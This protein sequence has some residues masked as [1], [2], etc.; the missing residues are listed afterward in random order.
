MFGKIL[1]ANR[2]EIACRIIQ[3]C[4]EL[5]IRT[6]AVYSQADADSLHVKLADEAV[7]IGPPP[8]RQSYLHIPAILGAA[9]ITRADAIHPGYGFLSENAEFAEKCRENDL[10]F[11]GPPPAAIAMMGH[12]AQARAVMIEAGVPV[13]PGSTGTLTNLDDALETARRIGF[14][15]MIKAAA[16]GG[17]RGMRIVRSE[18][19]LPVHFESAQAE[20]GAAFNNP[21]V[22]IEKYIEKPRHIEFQVLADSH[23]NVIHLGERECSI[24][25]R[26]QKLIEESPSPVM[27]PQLRERMGA[28]AVDACRKVGYVNAG[29]I[30]FLVD[31]NL[32]FYFMEMNTRIQVEH[33][34]TELVTGIDL[35]RWQ[36]RIAA[37]E[38]L[39]FTQADVRFTGHA[40]ECRLNAEDPVKFTPSPGPIVA[41]RFP[42]GP[43]VRVDSQLYAGYVVP[44]HYDSMIGKLVVHDETRT[45]AIARM[46]RALAATVIDG[47]KTTVPL[48]QKVLAEPD[49]INGN[50]S[51]R[52]MDRYAAEPKQ[53]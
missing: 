42:G 31:E 27:T 14:P 52:F 24:Q 50:I 1:I 19:E 21:A 45:A 51:T 3:A 43:G 39:P 23:G 30:E 9:D 5:G 10:T 47:V 13:M 15:V 32:D 29:T 33:P 41:L 20:A 46:Q 22:Y 11:I 17:G 26:H 6:V 37:G 40:I 25:R 16:G 34:V 28:A 4:R 18:T 35:V 53:R 7:C 48:H 44:P 2:G 12:K 36:I 49:F 8:S 38:R